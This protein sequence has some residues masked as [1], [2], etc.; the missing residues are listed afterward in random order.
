MEQG[1]VPFTKRNVLSKVKTA[2]NYSEK[3]LFE[4][5]GLLKITFYLLIKLISHLTSPTKN[6]KPR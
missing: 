2:S 3:P 1:Y 6:C 4:I 5:K